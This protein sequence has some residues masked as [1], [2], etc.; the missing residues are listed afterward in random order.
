[1]LPA[2][3]FYRQG[4]AVRD[5]SRD[6]LLAALPERNDLFQIGGFLPIEAEDAASWIDVV[7]AVAARS[8]TLSIDPNVPPSLISDFAGYSQRLSDFLDLAHL[9][10]VSDEDLAAL[11]PGKSIEEHARALL[12]RPHVELVVVTLG[13]GG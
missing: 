4:T 9:V 3:S 5:I 8:A 13:E 7:K 1:G 2:Y 12:A 10:K 6:L 11:D